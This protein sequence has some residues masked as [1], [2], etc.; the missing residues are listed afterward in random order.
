MKRSPLS[1]TIQGNN[2]LRSTTIDLLTLMLPIL[3]TIIG[4]KLF[5]TTGEK[6]KKLAAIEFP[7]ATPPQSEG[8]TSYK[9]YFDVQYNQ[10]RLNIS[11]CVNG[12]DYEKKTTY[13][14]YFNKTI[15]LGEVQ[16][17]SL[18]S[19]KTLENLTT[20]YDLKP[21][22][23]EEH[24]LQLIEAYRNSLKVAEHFKSLIPYPA[25]QFI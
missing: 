17:N 19:V 4:M 9:W 2:A 16:F 23:K 12:G 5:T 24:I 25:Q 14:E 15:E 18:I 1:I 21:L 11:V 10:L 6:T 3:K 7:T 20:H 22:P 13:C 8:H